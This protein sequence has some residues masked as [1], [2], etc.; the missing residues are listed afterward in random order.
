LLT[1]K[2]KQLYT[3]KIRRDFDSKWRGTFGGD[4]FG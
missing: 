2:P 4:V 1:S 3:G